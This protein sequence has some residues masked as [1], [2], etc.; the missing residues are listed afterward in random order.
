[1]RVRKLSKAD[2]MRLK[3][4]RFQDIPHSLWVVLSE[5]DLTALVCKEERRK[6]SPTQLS[7][8]EQGKMVFLPSLL[9]LSCSENG[10]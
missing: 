10:V 7:K 8:A 1:M 4:L 9:V 6:G 5:R 2:E 3:M